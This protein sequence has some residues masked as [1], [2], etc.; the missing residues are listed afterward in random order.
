MYKLEINVSGQQR[1]FL[2]RG[3]GCRRVMLECWRDNLLRAEDGADVRKHLRF[4]HR[5]QQ[6]RHR[7]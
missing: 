5:R 1:V 4:G 6:D 2:F 3:P 7:P